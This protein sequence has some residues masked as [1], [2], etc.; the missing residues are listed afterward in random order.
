MHTMGKLFLFVL[1]SVICNSIFAQKEWVKLG[2]NFTN[3]NRSS[4]TALVSTD[5]KL[6][7]HLGGSLYIPLSDKIDFE[8]SLL[9]SNEGYQSDE[10]ANI[11]ILNGP[12]K[13]TSPL[14][15]NLTYID[16]PFG[17]RFHST[18]VDERLFF[19]DA[20]FYYSILLFARQKQ[21]Y[22]QNGEQKNFKESMTIGSNSLD[23]VRR[24][25][26]GLTLGGGV[27]LG[28]VQIGIHYDFGLLN[29]A[30]N[31]SQNSSILNRNF[32]ISLAL[33]N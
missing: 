12:I 17:C 1:V 30:S 25:D 33:R 10:A 32:R 14:T 28:F 3:I 18:P 22:E 11:S 24:S 7:F 19:A 23:F 8:T 13:T 20:G 27:E 16:I 4:D 29:I 26:F 31:Q 15:T 2:L 9:Y 21:E 6:G 5:A